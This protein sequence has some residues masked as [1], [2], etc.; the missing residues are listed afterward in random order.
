M[1]ALGVTH[2]YSGAFGGRSVPRLNVAA[3]RADP[4]HYRLVYPPAGGVY[5]FEVN[6]SGQGEGCK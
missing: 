3:M 6:Y 4:C 1:K 2:V 5:I